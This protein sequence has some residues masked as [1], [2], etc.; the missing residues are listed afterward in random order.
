MNKHVFRSGLPPARRCPPRK[1]PR[2][3]VFPK[4][5]L[6]R[7]RASPEAWLAASSH[8]GAVLKEEEEEAEGKRRRAVGP[9]C[10]Q[11]SPQPGAPGEFHVEA[12]LSHLAASPPLCSCPKANSDS[13]IILQRRMKTAPRGPFTLV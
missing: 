7:G 3:F 11:T 8:G 12:H 13:S 1:S 4:R 6:A 9:T 5:E 10:P 2:T